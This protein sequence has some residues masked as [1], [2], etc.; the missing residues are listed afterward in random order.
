MFFLSGSF[1]SYKKL[2]LLLCLSKY[3]SAITIHK[4]ILILLLPLLLHQ[5]LIRV[6]YHRNRNRM[7]PRFVS[8]LRAAFWLA[9]TS[10]Q[11]L[12]K[13]SRLLIS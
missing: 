12:D 10:H 11:L 4:P 9:V 5:R 13:H 1:K 6:A 7:Q 8:S 2:R 3:Y